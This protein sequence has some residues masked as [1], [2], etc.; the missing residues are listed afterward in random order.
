MGGVA[1]KVKW[2]RAKWENVESGVALRQHSKRR[3]SREKV[4][5]WSWKAER[6]RDC[7]EVPFKERNPTDDSPLYRHLSRSIRG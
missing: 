7:L 3:E 2:K 1:G 5:T 6:E 4:T